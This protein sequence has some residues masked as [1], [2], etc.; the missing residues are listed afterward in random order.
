[1]AKKSRRM[2]M[3][4]GRKEVLIDSSEILATRCDLLDGS[5]A[6]VGSEID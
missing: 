5:L 4:L 6:T 2:D 3:D 1:M